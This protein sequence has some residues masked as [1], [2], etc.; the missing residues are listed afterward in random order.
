MSDLLARVQLLVNQGEIRVS[1][2]GFREIA[3]DAILLDDVMAGIATAI[4]IEEYPDFAK[5]PC[6]LVLQRDRDNRAV[7]VVWGIARNLTAP[8]VLV[9]AYRPDPDRWSA[10]F[11]KREQP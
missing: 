10:D 9:T 2:H 1:V 3:A 5:G 6:I 4:A 8:A 11:L 7:H